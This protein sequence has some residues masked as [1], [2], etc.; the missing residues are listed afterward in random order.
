MEKGSH[1][2]A[3]IH[4]APKAAKK[5]MLAGNRIKSLNIED[6]C[7]FTVM[8]RVKGDGYPMPQNDDGMPKINT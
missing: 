6:T 8:S 7:N 1:M 4:W 2:Q 3:S 5:Y